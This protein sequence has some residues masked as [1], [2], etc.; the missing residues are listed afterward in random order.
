MLSPILDHR[1]TR[2]AWACSFSLKSSNATVKTY[3]EPLIIFFLGWRW[4]TVFLSFKKYFCA[5]SVNIF[6]SFSARVRIRFLIATIL[7]L[8]AGKSVL[9]SEVTQNVRVD[10]IPKLIRSNSAEVYCDAIASVIEEQI[11][12]EITIFFNLPVQERIQVISFDI[13][14][15]SFGILSTF[16][17]T[18]ETHKDFKKKHTISLIENAFTLIKTYLNFRTSTLVFSPIRFIFITKQSE[19]RQWNIEFGKEMKHLISIVL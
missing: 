17:F 8:A 12:I 3:L 14:L 4:K 6:S 9:T 19:I 15:M 5:I 11:S 2:V 7:S 16:K 1:E 10:K 13:F 18:S